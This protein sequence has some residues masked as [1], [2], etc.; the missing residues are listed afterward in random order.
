M[1]LENKSVMISTPCYQGLPYN[2]FTVALFRMF[3]YSKYVRKNDIEWI[4]VSGSN[5]YGIRNKT[6]KIFKE[7]RFG[8]LL[9]ID[10]DMVFHESILECLFQQDKDVIMPIFT[11]K[12]GNVYE[13]NKKIIPMATVKQKNGQLR[14][15]TRGEIESQ[16][17]PMRIASNGFGM[18]L[19]KRRVI[20]EMT[21]PYCQ[22]ICLPEFENTENGVTGEDYY[23]CIEA[24]K[25][26]FEIW[27]DPTQAIIHLGIKPYGIWDGNY[28]PV[29]QLQPA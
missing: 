17:D 14:Q 25:K 11:N 27:L 6:F 16:A 9:L 21:F 20:E 29:P 4:P 2:D 3:E 1:K 10:N 28:E 13:I 5:I 8:S 22:G 24:I 19:V 12:A 15:L 18:V 26:G 7:S 23:F